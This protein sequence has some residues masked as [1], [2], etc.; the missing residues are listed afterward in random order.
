MTAYKQ[1]L[2]AEAKKEEE[3]ITANKKLIKIME[4]KIEKV[5][6]NV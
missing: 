6:E 1:Q 2:V 5:I 4:W 3:I